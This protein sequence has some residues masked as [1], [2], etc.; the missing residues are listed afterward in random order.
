[1]NTY[2]PVF[3]VI[4]RKEKSVVIDHFIPFYFSHVTKDD[5]VEVTIRYLK[6]S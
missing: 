6:K 3:T 4:P 1:M 5:F 2:I